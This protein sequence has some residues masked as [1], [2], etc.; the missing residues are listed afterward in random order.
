MINNHRT[1]SSKM[2]DIRQILLRNPELTHE[3]ELHYHYQYNLSHSII[4]NGRYSL[5]KLKPG[6]R[7]ASLSLSRSQST[8]SRCHLECIHMRVFAQREILTKV[9]E[10]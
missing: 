1:S 7:G 4:K 10:R 2:K 3:E 6:S 8:D 5:S 9:D